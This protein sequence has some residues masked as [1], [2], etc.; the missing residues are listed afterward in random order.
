[1]RHKQN[2][3]RPSSRQGTTCLNCNKNQRT[4]TSQ[5]NSQG[6]VAHIPSSFCD[7]ETLLVASNR[8]PG[9]MLFLAQHVQGH[10]AAQGHLCQ[11]PIHILSPGPCNPM[12]C[13][14]SLHTL[15]SREHLEDT[16]SSSD[17]ASPSLSDIGLF[18]QPLSMRLP[19]QG[20]DIHLLRTS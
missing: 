20:R 14:A 1:M 3:G 17:Q 12:T 11:L 13:N 15:P 7:T 18:G 8:L 10:V 16:L 5:F 19:D 2:E 4:Q 9:L 6:L